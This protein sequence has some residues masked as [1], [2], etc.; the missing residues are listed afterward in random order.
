M[1]TSTEELGARPGWRPTVGARLGLAGT[2]IG[3]V[4]V[5]LMVLTLV[6]ETRL[7]AAA[8][9][10]DGAADRAEAATRLTAAAADLRAAQLAYVAGGREMRGDY[11]SATVAFET[12]LADLRDAATDPVD[13]ALL[14]KIA[15]GYQTFTATDGLIWDEL[16]S[17]DSAIATN[18]ALGAEGLAYGFLADDA[19]AFVDR[20][21]ALEARADADRE[22]TGRL[23]ERLTLILGLG[24]L[25]LVVVTIRIV[26]R[27]IRDPLLEVQQAAEAA[28]GGNLDV[29]VADS[30]DDETARLARAFN[31]M[32]RR[33]RAREES[34]LTEHRR[35]ETARQIQAAL[36]LAETENDALAVAARALEQ[37]VP[38]ASAELLLADNSRAHLERA[39]TAGPDPA[40]P[41]C[42]VT[43]PY[44]CPAVRAGRALATPTSTA[45]DACPHLRDRAGGPRSA[46][47]VP[48]SFLGRALGVLHLTGP[49][50]E[51]IDE[52]R[53]ETVVTL[54]SGTGG[55]IGMLRSMARTQLQATT[56]GLTGLVNRRAFETRA[57]A[58]HRN[59]EPFVLVMADLDHFKILNDTYGHEAGDRA[60]RLFASVLTGATRD[61]DLVCR[62]GGEEFTLALVDTDCAAAA[63]TLERL[64][65]ELADQLSGSPVPPFTASF[66]YVD[67]VACRTFEEAVRRA[68][69]AL[70]AAK[71]AGR[72]R[73]VLADPFAPVDEAGEGTSPP[74]P[75]PASVAEAT[76]LDDDPLAAVE[77]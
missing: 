56:D 53:R 74:D 34:L 65:R 62:W 20:S 70:Y 31:V 22:A 49:D 13:D 44:S 3:L 7:D 16:T 58:M 71:H 38:E 15:T 50:N 9:E 26:T 61:E 76:P 25:V 63:E 54:A 33:L 6:A 32:L 52:E 29:V 27:A 30:G 8:Q 11:E 68:D 10:L 18:L 36:D 35:Q 77:S 67:A 1:D 46:L 47:C 21:L 37:T 41:G 73:A 48:V 17:G 24:A 14:T 5:G 19:A 23:V 40:G 43:S 66:G 64:R 4:V 51:P 39:V 12:A 57:R 2:V 42:D 45:L 60:L 75:A 55:R 28:A 59:G 69:R 72:D